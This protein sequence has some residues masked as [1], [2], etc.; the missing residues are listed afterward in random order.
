[1]FYI[2]AI[3]TLILIL[4]YFL[5][6][7]KINI[8]KLLTVIPLA[9]IPL[10]NVSGLEFNL[11]YNLPILLTVFLL[12]DTKLTI[13]KKLIGFLPSY[14]LCVSGYNQ[15]VLIF[16]MIYFMNFCCERDD[17]GTSLLQTVI[18]IVGIYIESSF[19]S[20]IMVSLGIGLMLFDYGSN[21]SFGLRKLY[22]VIVMLFLSTGTLYI[23]TQLNFYFIGLALLVYLMTISKIN[24]ERNGLLFLV[25]VNSYFISSK[26]IINLLNIYFLYIFLCD[27]VEFITDKYGKS[28]SK[29][30]LNLL[31]RGSILSPHILFLFVVGNSGEYQY[32]SILCVSIVIII[33]LL[34]SDLS[35]DIKDRFLQ[36]LIVATLFITLIFLPFGN[37]FG[38][39]LL[40]NSSEF[41]EYGTWSNTSLGIYILLV[42]FSIVFLVLSEKVKD[43]LDP[44]V[45]K[46]DFTN[47]KRTKLIYNNINLMLEK[48]IT[49][50][51]RKKI[52][53]SRPLFIEMLLIFAE[54][55]TERIPVI[56]WAII[57]SLLIT[58]VVAI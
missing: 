17:R 12:L 56:V 35:K 6:S 14:I 31:R 20:T 42:I 49:K 41:L 45:F 26:Q 50:Y 55:I 46:V 32:F 16:Q 57:L 15:L 10:T 54:F 22:S 58:M 11:V 52:K 25:I 21:N 39:F 23:N 5:K 40:L 33:N 13:D 8:S 38:H 43:I 36:K 44:I 2:V 7:K 4:D 48:D 9:V 30:Y 29:E 47:D 34:Y 51:D 19:V 1:M 37:N 3:C 18:F 27:L 53:H 24:I 28:K